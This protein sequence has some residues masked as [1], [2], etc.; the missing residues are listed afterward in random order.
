[1]EKMTLVVVE[2]INGQN[3]S[4]G[5]ITHETKVLTVTIGS[6]S[7]KIVSN[8]ISPLASFIIIGLS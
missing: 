5:P 6:Y 2:M 3:L 8:V 4:S 7:S 1:V